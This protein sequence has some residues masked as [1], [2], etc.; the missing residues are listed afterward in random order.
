[1]TTRFDAADI[2]QSNL[3]ADAAVL[4][5][6]KFSADYQNLV[7]AGNDVKFVK[8]ADQGPVAAGD[9]KAGGDPEIGVKALLAVDPKELTPN[10]KT[11]QGLAAHFDKGTDKA[12]AMGEVKPEV[13]KTIAASD[14]ALVAATKS[15]D[16][17]AATLKP[18][19]EAAA[20][21]VKAAAAPFHMGT[22]T[23]PHRCHANR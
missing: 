8:V 22:A 18:Q 6:A 3:A 20:A 12:K 4:S 7:A 10:L 14:A 1:M 19:Y 21:K 13:E 9:S 2:Q 5:G 17:E 23:A 16:T 15:A 11:L